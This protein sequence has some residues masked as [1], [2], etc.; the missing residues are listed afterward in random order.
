M[1]SDNT[2]IV[3]FPSLFHQR[4]NLIHKAYSSQ[5]KK[6][7][8]DY[9]KLYINIYI[10]IHK[11]I[12]SGYKNII[13]PTQTLIFFNKPDLRPSSKDQKSTYFYCLQDCKGSLR[14]WLYFFF[15][16][17]WLKTLSIIALCQSGKERGHFLAARG[18]HRSIRPPCWSGL[19]EATKKGG[20]RRS[21]PPDWLL[22]AC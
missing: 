10:H 15:L 14:K 2:A 18:P 1:T 8:A 12:S 7:L 21:Q 11:I 5:L 3:P 17:P 20:S 19:G 9:T 4:R 22:S 16:T 13:C 6:M